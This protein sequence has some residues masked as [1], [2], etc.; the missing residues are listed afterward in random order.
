VHLDTRT[1]YLVFSDP[2]CYAQFEAME[3][4]VTRQFNAS[5]DMEPVRQHLSIAPSWQFNYGLDPNDERAPTLDLENVEEA[6]VPIVVKGLAVHHEEA[7]TVQAALSN[8][9]QWTNHTELAAEDFVNHQLVYD[10]ISESFH[11]VLFYQT[12]IGH[13]TLQDR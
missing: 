13:E 4:R 6:S 9:T 11:S 3:E 8:L 5:M 10:P 2:A 7:K 1:L 12:V